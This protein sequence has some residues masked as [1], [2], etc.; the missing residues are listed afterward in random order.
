MAITTQDDQQQL[1]Q[2]E[3]LPSNEGETKTETDASDVADIN[4]ETAQPYEQS[5][6]ADEQKDDFVNW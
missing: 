1:N 6:S 4:Q 3:S 2:Q 5:V